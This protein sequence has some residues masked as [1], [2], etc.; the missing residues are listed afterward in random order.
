MNRQTPQANLVPLLDGQHRLRSDFKSLAQAW[1]AAK[2][3]WRDQ[4]R[5]RFAR[6][7]L[8]PLGPS[9]ARLSAA[10]DELHDVVTKADRQL[11]D[12]SADGP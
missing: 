2:E 11:A 7:H 8:D 6:E 4:R 9:L 3:Q 12:D 5:E 10:L 1:A